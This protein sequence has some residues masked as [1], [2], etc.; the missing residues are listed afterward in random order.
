MLEVWGRMQR[1]EMMACEFM[2]EDAQ[3]RFLLNH[4]WFFLD[5]TILFTA[6]KSVKL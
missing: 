3:T 1:A 5:S 4:F 2:A 6:G